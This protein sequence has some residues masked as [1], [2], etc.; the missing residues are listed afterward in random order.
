ML[1]IRERAPLMNI[2]SDSP[3]M[4][5][6]SI[7]G[8]FPGFSQHLKGCQ[9]RPQ[10]LLSIQNGGVENTLA[11]SRSGVLKLT[12][13]KAHYFW[14]HVTCCLPGSSLNCHFECREDPGD[15]VGRGAWEKI[16]SNNKEILR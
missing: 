6:L 8:Y 1:K 2:L 3:C 16:L 15:K 4:G 12:N 11:N 10:G 5:C 13:H 9:P 14:R 7:T